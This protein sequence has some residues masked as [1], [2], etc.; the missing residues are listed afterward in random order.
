MQD[1]SVI[2]SPGAD[3]DA[4]VPEWRR[5]AELRG[6]PF[7]TPEWYFATATGPVR[8]A[9]LRRKDGTLAGLLPLTAATW[10]GMRALRFGGHHLGDRFHPVA[11]EV[12]EVEVAAAGVKALAGN[13][14]KRIA[15]DN[16]ADE[17]GWL[18]HFRSPGGAAPRLRPISSA[19]L[20]WINLEGRDW[21]TYLGGLS[22]NLRSRIR[23]M[24]RK[25]IREH[26]MVVRNVT[27]SAELDTDF[28]TLFK[29]HDARRDLIGG[30]SLASERSRSELLAFCR[31]SLERGWLRLRI[32]EC[33]ERPVAAFLG[34]RVGGSYCFYQ[35]G[36]DPEWGRLS[37][38]LVNLSLA[39]RAAFEEGATE[40]DLL[41]GAEEYKLRLADGSRHV[42]SGLL[43]GHFDLTRGMVRGETCLRAA[44]RRA[45]ALRDRAHTNRKK[46][47]PNR[48]V[49]GRS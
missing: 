11:T 34:W 21:D 10:R 23:R 46:Q 26:G 29:L 49:T 25:L 28:K 14:E 39:I 7:V 20:P 32:M 5:L 33:D 47:A 38:G 13:G 35:T 18:E 3:L 43:T 15:L 24:E 42:S 44:L 27:E 30:T 22:K 37:I 45:R 8:I 16:C 17:S 40:F 6:N 9:A 19:E 41:L 4:L 36:F 12:D 31:A 2:D 48:A 1:Y